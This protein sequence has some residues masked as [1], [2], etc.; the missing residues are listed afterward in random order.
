MPGVDCYNE[1]RNAEMFPGGM[2]VVAHPPC[3]PWG[4]LK[5]F[6][7][8]DDPRS[9]I[10][11]VTIVRECG[12]VLEHPADSSLWRAMGLPPP[13]VPVVDTYGGYTVAMNQCDWGHATRKATWL[14]LVGVPVEALETPEP[15]EPTHSICNGRG[16]V[17]KSGVARL[18]ATAAQARQTPEAFAA[19]LVKLAR[20]VVP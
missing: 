1:A 9:G 12:G 13:W 19:Y 20:S 5:H 3:G 15:R 17:L 10:H 11:A 18:R 16:Q 2:P 6:A 7:K 4:R 8:H 14:Y